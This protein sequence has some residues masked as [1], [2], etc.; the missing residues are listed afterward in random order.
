MRILACVAPI[1][2]I[3]C[4]RGWNLIA[5]RVARGRAI[6]AAVAIAAMGATA[7]G[8]YV[9][10]PSH[11]RIFPLQRA[12]EFVTRGGLL[13]GAPALVLGDPMAEVC[14]HLPANVANLVANDSERNREC[15]D[16]LNAP[17]G[18]VGIW[19]NQHAEAWFHVGPADLGR[20][21]YSV[22]LKVH[23][24]PAVAIQWL[25]PANLPRDQVYVVIR[26]DHA[27]KMPD[28]V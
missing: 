19:D 23:Q 7:M 27:G 16:L 1:T 3:V 14:L 20:L 8:Y 21:G 13:S 12:C 25:E 15:E 10:E 26:K 22:L 18:S 9:V 6:L 28:G 4:L 5:E 17:F 2:A 11:Q 24:R